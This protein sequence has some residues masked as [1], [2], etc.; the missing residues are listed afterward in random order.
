MLKLKKLAE[1]EVTKEQSKA[2]KE[3]K[4]I[5]NERAENQELLDDLL[6]AAVNELKEQV[7]RL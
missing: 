1:Q 6:F 4:K 5:E 2:S 7:K 3:I